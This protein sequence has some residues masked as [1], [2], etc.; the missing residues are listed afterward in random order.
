MINDAMSSSRIIGIIQPRNSS[1]SGPY[2]LYDAGCVGRLTTYNETEDGRILVI[3]RSL[4]VS[5]AC[6]LDVTTSYRQVKA[7]YDPFS[8]DLVKDYGVDD[9]DPQGFSRC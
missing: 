5:G 6:E 3:D 7:D 9:V 4:P 8:H 1:Q 2:G